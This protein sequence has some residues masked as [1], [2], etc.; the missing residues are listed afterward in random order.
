MR[1]HRRT[2]DVC[3]GVEVS[4]A[5]RVA[6][7][8]P[9]IEELSRANAEM[10]E[11]MGQ[12]QVVN[13]RRVA[14]KL[15]AENERPPYSRACRVAAKRREQERDRERERERARNWKVFVQSLFRRTSVKGAEVGDEFQKW[16]MVM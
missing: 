8:T 3:D 2:L 4:Q 10:L 15:V 16:L 1:S 12:V 11:T 13:R 6:L 5:Q 7:L 9:Y 14:R